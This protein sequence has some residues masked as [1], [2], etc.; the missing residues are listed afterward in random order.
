MNPIK[1]WKSLTSTGKWALAAL[2]ALTV[3]MALWGILA[4]RGAHRAAQEAEVANRTDRAYGE[5]ARGAIDAITK[6]AARDR[7]TQEEIEDA[8]QEIRRLPP[9]ERDA[10]ALAALCGMR[11]YASDPRCSELQRARSR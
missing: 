6:G 1:L 3:A 10:A 9:A 7:K 8:I 4:A 5:S 11:E 2:T